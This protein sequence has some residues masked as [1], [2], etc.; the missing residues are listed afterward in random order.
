M[1]TK[2]GSLAES[3]MAYREYELEKVQADVRQNIKKKSS[4]SLSNFMSKRCL[5][6]LVIC[7]NVQANTLVPS[8]DSEASEHPTILKLAHSNYVAI[9][10][11]PYWQPAVSMHQRMYREKCLL[12]RKVFNRRNKYCMI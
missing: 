4:L 8:F 11:D 9:S 6:Y 10:E 12:L 2:I 5:K 3:D 7:Q 1:S